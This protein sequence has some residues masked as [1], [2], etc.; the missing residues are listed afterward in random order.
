DGGRGAGGDP[1]R[2]VAGHRR[3][4]AAASRC[5]HH[6]RLTCMP[7]SI[8]DRIAGLDWERLGTELDDAGFAQTP[9]VLGAAE[10]R[11]LAGRFDDDERFR[12]TID[13]RRHRFGEGR[14]RYFGAPLPDEVAEARAA[15]YGPL[16]ALA[17]RW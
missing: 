13:M 16:A 7:A 15:F 6:R 17:N 3:T 5:A 1:R 14:Y 11:R 10:C 2:L 12:S 9:P 4:G 8:T